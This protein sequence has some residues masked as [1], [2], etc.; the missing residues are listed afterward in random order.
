MEAYGDGNGVLERLQYIATMRIYCDFRKRPQDDASILCC[1]ILVVEVDS[2]FLTDTCLV[3]A[4]WTTFQKF[5]KNVTS[6]WK[7]INK[8]YVRPSK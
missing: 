6:E 8:S 5:K 7:S 1:I 3:I 4:R 2:G